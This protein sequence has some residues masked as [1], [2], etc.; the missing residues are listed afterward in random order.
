L[1]KKNVNNTLFGILGGENPRKYNFWQNVIIKI[2]KARWKIEYSF[3]LGILIYYNKICNHNFAPDLPIF[4]K[5]S[6]HVKKKKKY[7]KEF[8]WKWEMVER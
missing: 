7:K 6:S 8:L 5:L 3:L 2:K 4:F 1:I